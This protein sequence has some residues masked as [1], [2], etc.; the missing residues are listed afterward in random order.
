MAGGRAAVASRR[1][2]LIA[3]LGLVAVIALGVY[4]WA[5]GGLG[6]A[7]VTARQL[8]PSPIAVVPGIYIL[9]GLFPSVAYVVVSSEGLILIDSGL[10][11]DAGPLKTEM[12]KLG[13]DW[14]RVRAIL[15][16][17]AHGDHTGGAQSLRQETGARVYAGAGDA[18]VL[19]AG[20][21]REAFFSTFHMPDHA[22]RPTTV[23][24]ELRGGETIA[25]SD[26]RVQAIAAP[27]HT[28]GIMCYLAECSGLRALFA[29]D[30][31][32]IRTAAHRAGEA[33]RHLLRLPAAALPGRRPGFARDTPPSPRPLGPRPGLARPPARRPEAPIP[34][35][36]ASPVGSP[37]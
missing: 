29:G 7:G 9:G 24:V 34:T 35:T 11:P 14:K 33:A 27:G 25:V 20:G 30:V 28:P 3:A 23:D 6:A 36:V 13:L 15:L 37:P 10:A 18:A 26:V 12:A 8:A 5:P 21:P 16:T 2:C 4:S 17:H 22:P 1:V 31:I 19:S 32:T